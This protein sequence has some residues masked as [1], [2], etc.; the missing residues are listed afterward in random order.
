[1]L[2]KF[3]LL[4]CH[5]GPPDTPAQFAVS[6]VTPFTIA[7]QWV[8][9]WDN[10][11]PQTFH[12]QLETDEQT[13]ILLDVI[14]TEDPGY[15]QT[16]SGKF[17]QN[18]H[19]DTDY[20]VSLWSEN[21]LGSSNRTYFDLKTPD[22]AHLLVNEKSIN[23]NGNETMIGF[24]ITNGNSTM[25]TIECCETS[26]PECASFDF[27]I[28]HTVDRVKLEGIPVGT[29]YDFSF[30]L[31]D[32]EDLVDYKLVRVP[33]TAIDQSNTSENIVELYIML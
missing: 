25:L 32:H 15:N 11:E 20:E 23:I 33:S 21:D 16:G 27:T 9:M 29:V 1:M 24:S 13:P 26:I 17:S 4:L 6:Y 28:S 3:T 22:K 7:L 12:V 30:Y 19:P 10:G 14:Y 2:F 8:S 5:A 31:Y 18:I